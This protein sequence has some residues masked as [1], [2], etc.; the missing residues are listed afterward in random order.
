VVTNIII[1]SIVTIFVIEIIILYYLYRPRVKAYFGKT[2][3]RSA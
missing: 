3:P 1:T 2:T